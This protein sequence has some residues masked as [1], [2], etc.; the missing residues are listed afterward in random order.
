[1]LGWVGCGGSWAGMSTPDEGQGDRRMWHGQ[2]V[3]IFLLVLGLVKTGLLCGTQ[4]PT[5]LILLK[6]IKADTHLWSVLCKNTNKLVCTC[7]TVVLEKS[8]P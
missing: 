3:S 4:L 8:G 7:S 5:P 2:R 6:P 1:M